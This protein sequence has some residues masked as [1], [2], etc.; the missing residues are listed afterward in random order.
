MQYAMHTPWSEVVKNIY[1]IWQAC[2]DLYLDPVRSL[3]PDPVVTQNKGEHIFDIML[4]DSKIY[5]E[6]QYGQ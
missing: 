2:S 5:N 6:N 1:V 4:V 3:S